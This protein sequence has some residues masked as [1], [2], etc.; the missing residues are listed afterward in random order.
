MD[1]R[2][3]L[4]GEDSYQEV[5][6]LFEAAI[7]SMRNRGMTQWDWER[8]PTAELIRQDIERGQL[9]TARDDGGLAA[10]LV[11]SDDVEPEYA[12]LSWLYGVKPAFLRRMAIR[13][14]LFDSAHITQALDFAASEATRAG[15]DSLRL[16]VCREDAEMLAPLAGLNARHA[17]ELYMESPDR[18]YLCMEKPLTLACPML[19]IRMH[20]FYRCGEQTPWGGDGLK[21][22]YHKAI[23][24]ARTGEA[25]EIS[26]IPGMESVSDTGE[27]L[28]Q[29][30]KLDHR[31]IT[32]YAEEREFPLLLKLLCARQ[33]LSVQV[34]PDDAYARLHE[35]KLGKTE[36]WVI[37]RA[38]ENASI[39]YGV[40]DGVSLDD[41]RAALD[42]GEDVEPMIRRVPV[43]AGDVYYM[44]SGMVH[45][46]G[47]GIILYEI[48]QS[49]DVTYRLWDYNRVNAQGQKR[50]LHIRQSLDVIDA[51]LRGSQSHM[52]AE[53]RNSVTTLLDVPAF[54]L[55]GLTVN[56][57]LELAP[58]PT[59][60]RMLTAL[61]GLLLSWDGDALEL[62][63]GQSVLLPAACP[64][65]TLMGVG[66]ALVAME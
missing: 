60:F 57:E 47:G 1:M 35:N 32:G 64:A 34:H 9:Y 5:C 51:S 43:K 17:G 38:D 44:P 27:T 63:A 49:S 2:F 29:L 61:A 28:A 8:Y 11:L 39:L 59:G 41:L 31:R 40:N 4:T 22:V 58:H 42:A 15:Y 14:D 3:V 50:P 52:P 45:A 10:A 46:I 55:Q 36:A 54:K 24:D 66:A 37:L 23:P 6:A 18:T 20:P 16:D 65:V 53:N 56:G 30:L 33:P 26:A 7:A 25:L 13:P 48:Q 21:T 62:E 19:P 12:Q